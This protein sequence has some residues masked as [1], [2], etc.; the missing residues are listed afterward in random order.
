MRVDRRDFPCVLRIPRS[1]TNDE[2]RL[3]FSFVGILA[4]VVFGRDSHILACSYVLEE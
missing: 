3:L 1:Y 2:A 4:N